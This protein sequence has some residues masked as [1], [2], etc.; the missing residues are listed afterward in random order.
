[1]D[2]QD[3][4][5]DGDAA[6]TFNEPLSYTRER[7]PLC[8]PR[9]EDSAGPIKSSKPKRFNLARGF[10]RFKPGSTA[11]E[12]MTIR[13]QQGEWE[14]SD[15]KDKMPKFIPDTWLFF[16][17]NVLGK[18]VSLYGSQAVKLCKH[19]PDAYQAF[20]RGEAYYIV[21]DE[22]KTQLLTLEIY[23][24]KDKTNV[25]LKK[26]FKPDDKANDPNQDWLPT[27][28]HVIFVPNEDDPDDILDFVLM[29]TDPCTLL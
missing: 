5:C 2:S 1:M 16:N 13:R 24:Y 6:C 29:C 9:P 18:F 27:G 7:S 20:S 22:N 12:K 10:I 3:V 15:K 25:S 26:Y 23:T 21:I 17:D 11:S 19:L 4:A 28:H 8:G 14:V